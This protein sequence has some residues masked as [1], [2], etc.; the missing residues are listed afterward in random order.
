MS[1]KTLVIFTCS[2]FYPYHLA[3]SSHDHQMAAVA[4]GTA[5]SHS[6]IQGNKRIISLFC[7]SFSFCLFLKTKNPFP[8]YP[9]PAGFPSPRQAHMPFPKSMISK[10]IYLII[11]TNQYPF[12]GAGDGVQWCQK[13]T[14]DRELD[15]TLA[16][17]AKEGVAA[18][19][20]M[21]GI[22]GVFQMV[23]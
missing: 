3:C 13:P 10:R 12:P 15:K 20:S 11:L 4:S 9:T 18:V 2:L 19:V 1:S 6:N 23:V 21:L 7:V 17:L 22:S 14:A 5:S 8:D 16:L